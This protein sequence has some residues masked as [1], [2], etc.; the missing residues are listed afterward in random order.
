MREEEQVWRIWVDAQHRVV[1]F[2]EVADSQLLEFRSR[3]LFLRAVDEYARQRYR[4]Q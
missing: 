4:Y 1:S 3:E 2:H